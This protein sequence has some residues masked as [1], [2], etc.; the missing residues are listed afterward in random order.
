MD[1]CYNVTKTDLFYQN[2]NI[3]SVIYL[4]YQHKILSVKNVYSEKDPI[5]IGMFDCNDK[6]FTPDVDLKCVDYADLQTVSCYIIYFTYIIL[7]DVENKE[8]TRSS[9][10]K[11][12]M[13]YTDGNYVKSCR[14]ENKIYIF[15]SV[16][17]Y[18]ETGLFIFDISTNKFNDDDFEFTTRN[19]PDGESDNETESIF[20]NRFK[21]LHG[22]DISS[23]CT[24]N[25]VLYIV[26]D[27]KLHSY[28]PITDEISEVLMS[29]IDSI[30]VK[31]NMLFGRRWSSPH[32]GIL[33]IKKMGLEKTSIIKFK[34]CEEDE[35]V[36]FWNIY[37]DN[38]VCICAKYDL[39]K[40]FGPG[41]C[42]QDTEIFRIKRLCIDNILSSI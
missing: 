14:I 19:V 26:R 7:I 35:L 17:E 10:F 29:N 34:I 22:T 18:Y 38:L 32:G 42:D 16:C 9:P 1:Y 13:E 31:D 20:I 30:R 2:L 40:L 15:H 37:D 12:F 4:K 33:C 39:Y 11:Y 8:Y 24:D 28:D 23:C 21:N 27:N 3:P 25:G 6:K 41:N 36:R 5:S